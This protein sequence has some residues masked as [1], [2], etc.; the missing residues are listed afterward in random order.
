MTP[1]AQLA[2]HA[3]QAAAEACGVTA[4]QIAGETRHKNIAYARHIAMHLCRVHYGIT[5]A[6]TGELIGN[7]DHS[8]VIHA[9]KRIARL[10]ADPK[11]TDALNTIARHLPKR[12]ACNTLADFMHR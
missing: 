6:E 3:I 2:V 5:L 4:D 10:S 11:F 12:P 7:R 1:N 8:T 9:C